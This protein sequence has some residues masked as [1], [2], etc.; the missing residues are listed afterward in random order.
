MSGAMDRVFGDTSIFFNGNLCDYEAH[1]PTVATV[2]LSCE[3]Q[4]L[5]RCM[6]NALLRNGIAVDETSEVTIK[7]NDVEHI[8]L[9]DGKIVG[10]VKDVVEFFNK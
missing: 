5:A 10:S 6:T 9:P 1:L 7:I 4:N 3:D 2:R 8:A